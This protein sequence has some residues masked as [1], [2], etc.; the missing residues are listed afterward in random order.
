M[1]DDAMQLLSYPLDG[2][3]ILRKR[4]SIRRQLLARTGVE[5][6]E[7]RIAI[8]GGS[9]TADVR[10]MLELFLLAAGIRPAFS[11]SEY[12][13]YYEDAVFGTAELDAFH[14][15]LVVVWTSFVNLRQLPRPQDSAQAV[16]E[17]LAAEYQRFET[18]WEALVRRYGAAVVQN[19]FELPSARPL[20][21]LEAASPQGVSRF[22]AAMNER[23]A[24]Y[25]TAHDGFYLHDLHGVAMDLGLRAFHDAMQYHAFKFAVRYEAVPV[26]AAHLAHLIGAIF[27][28]AKKCLVLDLDHTLWGGVIGD[29]G[30]DG[31]ELGHE[32]PLAEAYTAFQQYVRALKERGVILA[33][34]S[35]NDDDV[36]RSGFSHPDSVLSVDDFAA[37]HANWEPKDVN[38]RAI[39]KELNIGLDSL[40]FIDDNPAERAIV[41]Q[42]LPEVAVPEVDADD[43]PSYIAAI[44][45]GGYFETAALSADDFQRNETYRAN[46]ERAALET[47]AASYDDYLASLEMRAEIAPFAPVYFDRI[48]QLTNKSNQFNLTTRRYTRADIARMADD[49]ACVTLYGRLA[50]RFGDNGLISVVVGKKEGTALRIDLW[51]MSCRVLKRGMEQAMLDVLVQQATATECTEILGEY[52]PTKKNKMVAGLYE[53]FG[54]T[55]VREDADGRTVWRLELKG[56]VPQARFIEV[57]GEGSAR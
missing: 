48:A 57:E 45:A 19:N 56:Y 18:M 49:P 26:V 52:L 5:Y 9:T 39:A 17:K 13:K 38:L 29:D 20:G 15:D 6:V 42:S 7:K 4:K 8:L 51:L 2:D 24:A 31:I 37:F 16:Q 27:G 53:S 1:S 10:D 12:G 34:C 36:A 50:D 11:E 14:P 43:V 55:K 21:S 46:R 35:K 54:F 28:K 44:E 33:V 41:R 30:V 40:V 23:F 25:A 47:S 3:L 32:T 22:V